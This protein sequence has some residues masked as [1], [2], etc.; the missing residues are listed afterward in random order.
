MAR[1]KH[2]EET[3]SRI[4]DVATQFFLEKGFE[5]TSL[6]DIIT[7]TG[8]SKGALYHHFPGKEE[9]FS[10]A[11]ERM[12]TEM[13][14]HHAEIRDDPQLTGAQKLQVMFRHSLQS[15]HQ[16]QVLPI[17]PNLLDS[18]KLLAMQIREVLELVVPQYVEPVVRQGVADGSIHTDS[19][20]ELAQVMMLLS[21][22]WLPP[23]LC[24]CDRPTLVRRCRLYNK[25]LEPFG[26]NVFDEA[27][28]EEFCEIF[29]GEEAPPA[30]A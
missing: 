9:L 24:P 14:A 27:L 5:K 28:L 25:M 30:E 26:L 18:P 8:F 12:T 29:S 10:A 16:R 4:L 20:L 3:I 17:I 1:N 23:I 15:P 13:V 19:P 6:Q 21:D 7:A 11:C 2:P 22:L